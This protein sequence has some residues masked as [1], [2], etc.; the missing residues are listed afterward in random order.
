MVYK[1]SR[2]PHRFFCLACGNEGI[3]LFR[4]KGHQHGRYHRKCLYCPYC[5]QEVNHFE[6]K[7]DEDVYEFR[8][9]F[10]A[11]EFIAEAQESIQYIQKEKRV[12]L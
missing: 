8:R 9:R 3:S 10:K 6:C 5:K 1:R 7:T 12:G 2:E 11:G 4:N